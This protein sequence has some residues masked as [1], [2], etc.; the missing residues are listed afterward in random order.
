MT[1]LYRV[2]LPIRKPDNPVVGEAALYAAANRPIVHAQVSSTRQVHALIFADGVLLFCNAT[3]RCPTSI[4][5]N[6]S[7]LVG[8]PIRAVAIGV[9]A[10]SRKNPA[11]A[12]RANTTDRCETLTVAWRRGTVEVAFIP[13]SHEEATELAARRHEITFGPAQ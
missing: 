10:R 4:V 11:L 8:L 1:A 9:D 3:G 2:K 13:L 7:R 5:G 12:I 6:T